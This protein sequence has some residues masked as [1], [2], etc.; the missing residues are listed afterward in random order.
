MKE[1]EEQEE[2]KIACVSEEVSRVE[3]HT[4]RCKDGCLS[5]ISGEVQME[6]MEGGERKDQ[7]ETGAC[8]GEDGDDEGGDEDCD[9]GCGGNCGENFYE[10]RPLVAVRNCDH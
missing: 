3:G 6:G 10:G 8:E 4:D 9:E 5:L 1:G 7:Q 2:E